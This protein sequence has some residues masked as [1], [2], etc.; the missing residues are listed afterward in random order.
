MRWVDWLAEGRVGRWPAA[1]VVAAVYC[2]AQVVIMPLASWL[3]GTGVSH[4]DAEQLMYMPYLWL[5]YGGSQPPLYSWLG[6]AV[7]SVV[8]PNILALKILKYALIF[9]SLATVHAT[10]RWLGHSARAAAAAMFGLLLFPQIFWE[11]QRQL[12]HSIAALLFSAL[13][14]A[15]LFAVL[16]RGSTLAYLVLGLVAA[17]AVL[18]KFNNL[19]LLA[20]LLAAAASMRAT[21]PAV[22]SPKLAISAAVAL[23]ALAP[24][25]YWSATHTASVMSRSYKFGMDA[26]TNAVMTALTGTLQLANAAMNFAI[27]PVIVIVA[28]LGFARL[29]PRGPAADTT[30]SLLWRTMEFGMALTLV[31]VLAS[32][33]TRLSDR[34]LLPVLFLLPMTMAIRLDAFGAKGRTAQG[35]M[36]GVGAVLALGAMPVS[37]FV[38]VR[39]GDG[40]SRVVQMQYGDLHR[41][42]TR[43]GAVRTFVSDWHWVGNLRLVDP[44]AVVLND[45]VPAFTSLIEEPA[46]LVWLDS[47]VPKQRHLDALARGGFAPAGDYQFV[48]APEFLS[49]GG[50]RVGFVRLSKAETSSQ[51][52]ATGASPPELI[53]QP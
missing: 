37:W 9:A 20:A 22:K 17:L 21:R 49:E 2:V 4:D 34:W 53:P 1:V 29:M 23:A 44:V 38:Q 39:A 12:S 45:E 6:W 46:M 19:L 42:L 48:T 8:G 28:A 43:D 11:M 52:E 24:T 33:T 26:E 51:P 15:A 47:D 13:L 31:L 25:I 7:A 36:I 16:R 5:G 27:L 18:S 14:V 10:V 32:G 41:S 3:A 35:V 30:E 40:L 50:R